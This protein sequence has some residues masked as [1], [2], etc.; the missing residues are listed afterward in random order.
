MKY[1]QGRIAR[2]RQRAFQQSFGRR[3]RA[4]RRLGKLTQGDLAHATGLTRQHIHHVETGQAM[5]TL[6]NSVAI[7][8][9][10]SVGVTALVLLPRRSARTRTG[11]K[12]AAQ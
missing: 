9:A 4:L 11:V 2:I 7:A 10:L 5:P 12:E 3:V 1:A 8:E 6:W